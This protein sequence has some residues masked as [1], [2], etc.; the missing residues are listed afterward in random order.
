MLFRSANKSLLAGRTMTEGTWERICSISS[1]VNFKKH[2]RLRLNARMKY[3]RVNAQGELKDVG[4]VGS[5]KY[6][7]QLDT[8]G[9]T[10]GINRQLLI[11]DD[12]GA[13][14]Q[15]PNALGIGSVEAI[16]EELYKQWLA[17]AGG[18]FGSGNGNLLT[19]TA[20]VDFSDLDA[21][22]PTFKKLKDSLGNRLRIDPAILFVPTDRKSTR[23]NSSH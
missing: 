10:F 4:K 22:L 3:E 15:L 12:M 6:E 5:E 18:F 7:T 19:S 23:L 11:D 9:L 1:N 14:A 21:A 20:L 2:T 16:N 8:Y 17:N 13:F